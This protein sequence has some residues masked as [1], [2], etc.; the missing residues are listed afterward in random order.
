MRK[1]ATIQKIEDVKQV[2]DSDNL[3]VVTIK[4]WKVVTKRNEFKEGGLCI[5]FE[6]DS[7]LPILPE[8]EFLRKSCYKKVENKEGFRLKTVKLRG[9]IS[10]GLAIPVNTFKLPTNNVGDCLDD[11]LGVTKYEPP[12]PTQLRGDVVGLFPR[13]IPKTDQ[14]RI[15][16]LWLDVDNY[17]DLYFEESLKLDGASMTV[18][19]KD[20]SFGVCSRNYELKENPNNTFWKVFYQTGLKDKILHKNLAF[21]GE[22]IGEGIQKNP[23]KIVGHKWFIFDIWDIDEQQY[24]EPNRRRFLCDALGLD[25][26]PVYNK[27]IQILK[28][29]SLETLL[30]RAEGC[31]WKAPIREGLVYKSEDL[32]KDNVISFKV[33]SNSFLLK[34]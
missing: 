5:Y 33:I 29:N 2:K 4:G 7:F 22:L 16:N 20:G 26:V 23:E 31:S 14:E 12:I 3:D 6:I 34:H 11:Y 10:Q 17:K 32:Y 8:F 25:H 24:L 21:Q 30:K 1:L 28:D 19:Y 18:F 15:Q 13:F 27:S 9:Q